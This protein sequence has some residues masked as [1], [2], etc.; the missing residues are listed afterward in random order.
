M[1]NTIKTFKDLQIWQKAIGFPIFVCILLSSIFYILHP[2]FAS[3]AKYMWQI[4]PA[5]ESLASDFEVTLYVDP[6]GETINTVSGQVVWPSEFL[7]AL[8]VNAGDSIVNLW[9]EAPII[10]DNRLS[11][12]GI[13]PGGFSGLLSPYYSGVRPGKIL[14]LILRPLKKGQATLLGENGQVLLNDGSGTLARLSWPL[15]AVSLAGP[16]RSVLAPSLDTEPPE[17]FNIEMAR[18]K[19]I[20][21]NDWFVAF[22]TQDKKS[23]VSH[24]EIQERNKSFPQDGAWRRVESPSRLENQNR[25]S[26]VFVRA[27]DFAGNVRLET[28][29]P[30][31]PKAWYE[32]ISVWG[33]LM[34]VLLTLFLG[35][36]LWPKH[37]KKKIPTK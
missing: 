11:F 20:F 16:S 7:S 31:V 27:L 15:L 34:I 24:Y 25:T 10:K 2:A 13:M 18:D 37:L 22:S 9:V 3:A 32:N 29:A 33:I 36:A 14:T 6:E 17:T 30:A 19:N 26:Y 1:M 35:R 4:S 12:S 21:N 28:L 8:A 5:E 23:G